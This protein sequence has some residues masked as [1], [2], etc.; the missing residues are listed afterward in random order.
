MMSMAPE[1]RETITVRGR[2]YFSRLPKNWPPIPLSARRVCSVP[3]AFVAGGGQ[4]RRAERGMG[5]QYFG[6]EIGLPSYSKIC[7][8]CSG[9][10]R[11]NKKNTLNVL[12]RRLHPLLTCSPLC[13]RMP[14]SL[15]SPHWWGRAGL[16]QCS[17]WRWRGNR[18][19]GSRTS[20]CLW[21]L[22]NIFVML[23]IYLLYCNQFVKYLAS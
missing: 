6:R 13:T 4:T 10:K 20:A 11:D 14:L 23:I 1:R 21:I 19:G 12:H 17:S 22:W 18:T 3:P 16:V 7:T 9:T 15:I 2:S 5:G 8:L